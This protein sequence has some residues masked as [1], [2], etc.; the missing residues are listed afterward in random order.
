MGYISRLKMRVKKKQDHN[1]TTIVG[2]HQTDK[3]KL[4]KNTLLSGQT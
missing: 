4:F 1:T 2:A 3:V